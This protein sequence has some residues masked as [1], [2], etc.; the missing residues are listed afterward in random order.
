MLKKMK[1][2][3]WFKTKSELV[4]KID[5]LKKKNKMNYMLYDLKS[6][7]IFNPDD[8][9]EKVRVLNEK[10]M[11][12]MVVIENLNRKLR[13]LEKEIEPLRDYKYKFLML[14]NSIEK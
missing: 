9:Y 11:D 13:S 2:I 12:D 8:F 6:M 3:N 5:S 4:N 7:N 14:I 10:H 1:I